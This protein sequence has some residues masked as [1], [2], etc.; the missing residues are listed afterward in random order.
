M[1]PASVDVPGTGHLPLYPGRSVTVEVRATSDRYASHNGAIRR[2]YVTAYPDTHFSVPARVSLD[3]RK[4][5]GFV[6][7]ETV[8]GWSTP[9][10]DDPLIYRFVPYTYS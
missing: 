3:G 8:A 5:A 1:H 2:A 9:T 10:A 7:V 4:V 6:T